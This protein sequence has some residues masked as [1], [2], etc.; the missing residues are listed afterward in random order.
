[1]GELAN[2]TGG[3]KKEKGTRGGGGRLVG[4]K[5]TERRGMGGKD[6]FES[7]VPEG[8]VGE[9]RGREMPE[10]PESSECRGG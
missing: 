7:R 4:T 10:I 8:E 5:S 9:A 6:Q 3:D 1:M 2:G